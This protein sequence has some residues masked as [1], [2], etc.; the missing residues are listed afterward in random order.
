MIAQF[1][2][3]EGNASIDIE[4]LKQVKSQEFELKAATSD[5]DDDQFQTI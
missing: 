2:E 4:K 5:K 3:D 1:I